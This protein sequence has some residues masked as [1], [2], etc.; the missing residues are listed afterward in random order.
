MLKKQPSRLGYQSTAEKKKKISKQSSKP[1]SIS[2]NTKPRGELHDALK[3]DSKLRES[4][5][6]P[7]KY[8]HALEQFLKSKSGWI[9]WGDPSWN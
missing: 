7:G 8:N 2:S 9:K 6:V 1:P 5:F 3:M 4:A